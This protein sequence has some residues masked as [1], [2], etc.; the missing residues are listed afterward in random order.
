MQKSKFLVLISAL[1]LIITFFSFSAAAEETE[2]SLTEAAEILL[3][4]NRQLQNSRQNIE[5]AEKDVDLSGRGY[6]P[7]ANL[8]TSY[9]K[10]ESGQETIDFQTL[11][12]NFPQSLNGDLPMTETADQNYSTSLSLNQPL[13][14]GGR[15]RIGNDISELG[16]EISKV[17]YQKQLDQSLFNL[18]QSYYGVLQAQGMVE[19]RQN[20]LDVVNEHLRIVKVNNEAGTS[21]RQDLLQTQ[22]EQ[23]KAEEDLIAAENQ[24]QI[25]RKRLAQLL[26]DSSQSY[27]V[28]TPKKN[29]EP[30]TELDKLINIALENRSELKS[31]NINQEMIEKQKELEGNLY[32]PQISLNGSYNWQGSELDFSDGSWNIT[33]SGSIPLY[34]GGKANL[35]EEKKEI[36]ASNLQNSKVDL[37]ESIKIEIEDTLL[38][39]KHSEEMIELEQLSLENAE[40]NLD[41]TN[42]SY[43]AGIGTNIDVINAQTSY[44][45]AQI[46]LL[47][48]EY[49][50]EINL[51]K[52]LYN[53]G[54]ISELFKD[55]I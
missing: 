31:L 36:E 37:E 27:A 39:L 15:V 4:N 29:P 28:S 54:R 43:Q 35:N 40:E 16:L 47:Q 7:T 46:S 8:Q 45:Q 9:T 18:V 51:Y 44:K 13:Y 3:E 42:K 10:M 24:L 41:L 49:N 20:A 52:L 23:R 6:Y 11:F 53:T 21:L 19:I 55:V 22:I 48:A 33:L 14:L 5:K 25:A 50:Y 38:S 30:E 26:G 12:G 17:E 1:L 2:I 34:D 32:R